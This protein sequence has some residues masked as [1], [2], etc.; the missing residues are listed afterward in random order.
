MY[1]KNRP[2]NIINKLDTTG[3]ISLFAISLKFF[4]H[5][6]ITEVRINKSQSN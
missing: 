3:F 4:F 6:D 2:G 1:N 5:N